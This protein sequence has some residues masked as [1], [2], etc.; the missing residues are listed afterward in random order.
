M[1]D[2]LKRIQPEIILKSGVGLERE[3]LRVTHQGH[4][5]LSEHPQI[6]GNKLEN[7]YITT[8]FSESQVELITPVFDSCDEACDFLE[9]LSD[10]VLEEIST[11]EEWLWPQSMPCIID[12]EEE[13]PIAVYQGE[14]GEKAFKYREKLK[15]KY[16]GKRQLISGLHYNFSFSDELLEFLWQE[17][18]HVESFQSFKNRIYLKTVRNYLRFRWLVIY[19]S[20]AS[21]V[22]HESYESEEEM[23]TV[24]FSKD[25]YCLKNSISLRNGS[26]TGYKNRI[27]LYP[28][29]TSLET[30]IDSVNKFVENGEISEV[31]E[32]YSQIRLKANDPQEPLVSLKKDGIKYLEI[33]TLD[34]NPFEKRGIAK[35]DCEFL[36]LLMLFCLLEGELLYPTWQQEAM[37]NEVA[38]AE[39]GLEESLELL[40]HQQW[41]SRKDWALDILDKMMEINDYLNLGKNHIIDEMIQRTNNLKLTYA[42]RLKEIMAKGF[43]CSQLDLAAGHSAHAEKM[44]YRLKGFEDWELST[45]ILIKEAITRGIRVIPLDKKENIICLKKGSHQ[46]IIKQATKTSADTYITPIIMENKQVTKWVL[47]QHGILVPV[48]IS[49]SNLN[50]A[51]RVLKKII[52]KPIV[53]KPKSTN[54]GIGISVFENGADYE[55]LLDA[56]AYALKYD[57]VVMIEDYV[58]GLEFRF[59]VI[60]NEVVAVLHRRPANVVGD[61]KKSIAQLVSLKNQHPYRGDG[62]S[63][64]LKLIELDQQV[65]AFLTSQDK[66]VDYIPKEGQRVY[67]RGNSNIS[68]GGDSIDFSDLIKESFKQVALDAAKAVNATFCGVDMIIEDY[69]NEDSQFSIIEMNYNPMISMQAFP[70]EGKNRRLGYNILKAIRFI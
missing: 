20:G 58:K 49:V 28:D 5:A 32:L 14:E 50:E 48:D 35:N 37:I 38:V 65:I 12:D 61:G 53:I 52:N 33:R 18:D 17:Y 41:T 47:K 43:T 46:E 15:K 27:D 54:F 64:P 16:G 30:Y 29:Y 25:S 2:R 9:A 60:G 11:Q 34:L 66:S 10:I 55:S 22:M 7:P 21:P 3:S 57:P 45:Q 1:I 31:K 62:K 42:Y 24:A 36:N 63:T 59:L 23:A 68:T 70:F 67:L 51:R 13:I 40:D 26:K 8:D 56:V 39:K 6:F 19:L 69:E 4:L 44:N